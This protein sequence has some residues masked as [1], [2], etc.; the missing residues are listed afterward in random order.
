MTLFNS[1]VKEGACALG[2]LLVKWYA[3]LNFAQLAPIPD[4]YKPDHRE[5]TFYNLSNDLF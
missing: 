2:M 5:R 4:D 3:R 1:Q